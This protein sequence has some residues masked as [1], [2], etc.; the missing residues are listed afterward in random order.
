MEEG[1][2]EELKALLPTLSPEEKSYWLMLGSENYKNLVANLKKYIGFQ[3]SPGND[4]EVWSIVGQA[5][6]KI[7]EIESSHKKVLEKL[8]LDLVL[9]LDE[10]KTYKQAYDD[11]YLKISIS[12]TQPSMAD[13]E[14]GTYEGEAPEGELSPEEKENEELA[15]MFQGINLADV[16][17]RRRLAN[18]MIAGGS[19]SKMYLFHLAEEQ[20]NSIDSTLVNLYGIVGVVAEYLYWTRTPGT[21]KQV[22][23]GGAVGVESVKAG[24]NGT[25]EI[26]V[27]AVNFCYLCHELVK[28]LGELNSIDPELKDVLRGEEIED[29][30]RDVMMG[31]GLF[32][33]IMTMIPTDEQHLMPMVQRKLVY[34][35]TVDAQ[36]I[37]RQTPKGKEIFNKLVNDA[38]EEWNTYQQARQTH[39]EV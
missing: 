7:S 35:P 31:P 17:T 34:L 37:L 6:Q 19:F 2:D 14:P 20:L 36:E 32:K 3:P 39:E 10:F 28:A 8:A 15:K 21:E 11:G 23:A 22:Q 9:G 1:G 30:T 4:P 13:F 26:T 12:L 38:R 18:L 16:N 33:R 24:P 5:S 29:E 27:K 25:Y